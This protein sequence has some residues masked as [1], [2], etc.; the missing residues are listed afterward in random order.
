MVVD[1]EL[2][3][4][5]MVEMYLKAWTFEVDAF[6]DPVEA[7]S[8]FLFADPNRHQDAAHDWT[9]ACTAYPANKARHENHA[10][11]CVSSRFFRA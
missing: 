2:D 4:L 9:R 11:D 8:F 1:D 7:L 10:N 3:L 6:S 5:R